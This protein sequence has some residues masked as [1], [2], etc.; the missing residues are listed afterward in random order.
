MAVIKYLLYSGAA[1]CDIVKAAIIKIITHL[2]FT[3]LYS[4]SIAVYVYLYIPSSTMFQFFKFF[5]LLLLYVAVIA[6]ECSWQSVINSGCCR[7]QIQLTSHQSGM[8]FSAI[9]KHAI[10]DILGQR[11]PIFL[12]KNF[13]YIDEKWE[14]NFIH[15]IHVISPNTSILSPSSSPSLFILLPLQIWFRTEDREFAPRL[16]TAENA[17]IQPNPGLILRAEPTVTNILKVAP[18]N[19]VWIVHVFN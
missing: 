6:L 16:K 7:I 4:N 18:H 8:G 19:H 5:S 12:F 14:W 17:N 9:R 11:L 3:I 1:V 10:M 15:Y 13:N 2:P